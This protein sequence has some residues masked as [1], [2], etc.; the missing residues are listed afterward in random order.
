MFL[1]LLKTYLLLGLLAHKIL[2]EVMKRQ[3][4][5]GTDQ[6]APASL[7]LKLIKL[8]KLTMLAGLV[9][10]TLAPDVFPIA[11]DP[12]L[13]RLAGAI[14]FALGLGLAMLAR[15]QLEH[16]WSDIE[17]GRVLNGHVVK[18]NGVYGYLRHP[19]YVG[20]LLLLA[21]FELSLNSWLVLGVLLLAPVVI[22]QAVAEEGRL[23]ASLPGYADYASRTKRFIPFVI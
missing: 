19:I 10:Q 3:A 5:P 11:E 20:D 4:R 8:G 6:G 22:R 21:G 7:R 13:L 9:V 16:N 23:M 12:L 17:E 1:F 18:A 15:L 14:V 2:W